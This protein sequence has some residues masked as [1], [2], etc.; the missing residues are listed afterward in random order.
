MEYM[1]LGNLEVLYDSLLLDGQKFTLTEL[2]DTI[3]LEFAII[4]VS[5]EVG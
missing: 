1:T 3:R 5:Q 2:T 4:G